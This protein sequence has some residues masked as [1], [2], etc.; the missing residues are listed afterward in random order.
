M[1]TAAETA[2]DMHLNSSASVFASALTDNESIEDDEDF[3][4]A[5]ASSASDCETDSITLS[6]T[7]MTW[8]VVKMLQTRSF[9]AREGAASA[10][11]AAELIAK[12]NACAGLSSL[13]E[14]VIAAAAAKTES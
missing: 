10:A 5:F 7:L 3:P 14:A 11:F 4:R 13:V 12:G 8:H 1:A 9:S 2:L 6:V